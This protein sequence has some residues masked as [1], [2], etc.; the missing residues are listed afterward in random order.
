MDLVKLHEVCILQIEKDLGKF[1][2]RGGY[3]FVI[4]L[5]DSIVSCHLKAWVHSS[6]KVLKYWNCVRLVKSHECLFP[7][8]HPKN[9]HEILVLIFNILQDFSIFNKKNYEILY[10]K[11]IFL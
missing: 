10:K 4:N 2:S 8:G 5:S 11:N 3:K 6:F 1:F 9:I 7:S